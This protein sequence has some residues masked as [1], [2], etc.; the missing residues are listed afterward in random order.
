M[1]TTYLLD[2]NIISHMMRETTGLA[3]QRFN[4]LARANSSLQLCTSVVV[5]CELEFGLVRMPNERLQRAYDRIVPLLDVL[6]LT[7]EISFHYAALRTQLESMGKPIGPNDALIAAHALALDA[8]LV[9]ADVE[10]L[11]VSGLKVENWLAAEFPG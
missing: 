1:S 5:Q 4:A 8:T 11:R 9:S 7:S 10:F 2:T 3:T 6:P